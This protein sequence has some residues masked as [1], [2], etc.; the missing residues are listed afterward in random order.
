MCISI[1][2]LVMLLNW[3]HKIIF[4]NDPLNSE[5][6]KNLYTTYNFNYTY[7]QAEGF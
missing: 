6:L 3:V 1:H 2:F 4:S 7:M 5:E